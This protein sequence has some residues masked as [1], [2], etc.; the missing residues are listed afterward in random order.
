MKYDDKDIIMCLKNA[1]ISTIEL[2][3]EEFIADQNSYTK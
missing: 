2:T 1:S 3:S